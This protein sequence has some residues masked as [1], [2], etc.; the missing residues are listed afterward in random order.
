[1]QLEI[2]K[3]DR[4]EY[5]RKERERRVEEQQAMAEHNMRIM[6]EQ[7]RLRQREMDN[8]RQIQ[9]RRSSPET[10]RRLRELIRK[11]YQLDVEI[12]NLRGVRRV[13]Q[14]I[15]EEKGRQADAI[16]QEIYSIVEIWERDVFT[17]EEWRVAERIKEQIMLP[18]KRDWANNPPWNDY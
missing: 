9:L 18:G 13:D 11:R 8:M 2:A 17:P 5:E 16:L 1:M 6:Q 7:Q 14:Y 10:L 4:I 3:R 15:V 12:W